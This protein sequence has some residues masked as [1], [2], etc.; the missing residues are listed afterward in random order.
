MA[1]PSVAQDV[2]AGQLVA[3]GHSNWADQ[4]SQLSLGQGQ[5]PGSWVNEFAQ[6]KLA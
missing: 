2:A 1:E 6:V 4:F 3:N 5:Q